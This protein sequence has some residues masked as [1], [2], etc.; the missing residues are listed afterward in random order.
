M[1]ELLLHK[2]FS[3][4]T[5]SIEKKISKLIWYIPGSLNQ[6]ALNNLKNF[7]KDHMFI[8]RNKV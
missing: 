3:F 8:E 2:L 7:S 5:S 4:S 1:G 6:E